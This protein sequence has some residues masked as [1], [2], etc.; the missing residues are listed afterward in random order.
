MMKP[1]E[2]GKQHMDGR[3][4]AIRGGRETA[5]ET[6]QSSEQD[7]WIASYMPFVVRTVSRVTGRY[8]DTRNSEELGVA[9]EAFYEAVRRYDADRG[10]FEGYAATL[11]RHRIIDFWRQEK[12]RTRMVPLEDED[13]AVA[14]AGADLEQQ[15][16]LKLEIREYEAQLRDYGISFS[17]L[18]EVSPKH[19]DTRENLLRLAREVA[20]RPEWI[21]W[22]KQKKRLPRRQMKTELGATDRLMT[23]NRQYLLAAIV[24]LDSDLDLIRDLVF[25]REEET[26]DAL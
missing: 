14:G 25:E 10:S 20:G 12:D 11:I 3:L 21:R 13:L 26:G 8:V 24:L 9:M 18:A 1:N 22:I 4:R 17:K 19:R 2:P 15:E 5:W 16:M 23:L 7:D 6:V